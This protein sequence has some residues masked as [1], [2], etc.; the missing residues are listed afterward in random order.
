M[1]NQQLQSLSQTSYTLVRNII[2]KILQTEIARLS[3]SLL[4]QFNHQ[5]FSGKKRYKK[6]FV[7]LKAFANIDNSLEKRKNSLHRLFEYLDEQG[8]D[9][10]QILKQLTYQLG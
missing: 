8:S 10:Q 3:E 1:G 9:Q 6:L 2:A 4:R 7:H 5:H